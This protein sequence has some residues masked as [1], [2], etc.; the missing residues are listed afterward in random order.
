M[1]VRSL[2]VAML[3]VGNAMAGE[4]ATLG[5]EIRASRDS[6]VNMMLRPELKTLEQQKLVKSTADAVS[7]HLNRLTPPAGKAAQF[8][9]LKAAWAA[10]K[11]LR[12]EEVV[13]AVVAGDYEKAKKLAGGVQKE[14]LARC[15][16]LVL[17]LDG[18]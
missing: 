15:Q 13:P 3:L 4:F 10:F 9:E 6:L 12:E 7:A 1:L 18:V 2:C 11:K 17:E 5:A 16:A 8:K 14:R